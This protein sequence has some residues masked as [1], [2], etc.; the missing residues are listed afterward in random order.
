MFI[1]IIALSVQNFSFSSLEYCSYGLT[2]PMLRAADKLGFPFPSDL[3][4]MPVLI[5]VDFPSEGPFGEAMAESMKG[6]AESIAQEP[7]LIWKVWTE[8]EATKEAGGVYLFTDRASAEA[9]LEMHTA[10]LKGFG[11]PKIN[12]KIFD[13]NEKLSIID[14]A[15]LK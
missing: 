15:P 11:I 13:V 2:Y 8:N 14:K 9:Y 6:L 1:H 3:F 4:P 10:R 7:G 12:A 5:A